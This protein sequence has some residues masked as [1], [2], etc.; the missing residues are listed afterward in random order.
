[1]TMALVVAARRLRRPDP[2]SLPLLYGLSAIFMFGTLASASRLGRG[3]RAQ[4]M[5]L[6]F[7]TF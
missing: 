5:Q 6:S 3:A 2:R 7:L 4:A 1:M